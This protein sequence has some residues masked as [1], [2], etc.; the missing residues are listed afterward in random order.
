MA[1]FDN[2]YRADEFVVEI[3]GEESPTVSKVTGLSRGETGT[4]E[5][6][7][8]G[9]NAV[10]LVSDGVVKWPTLTIERYIDGSRDD[11]LFKGFFEE[12]FKLNEG[13]I[14]SNCRR[15]I[16]IVK[17]HFGEEVMRFLVYGAFPTKASFTD[18]EAGSKNLFKETIEF[19]H[20]GIR[21]V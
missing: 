9:T 2:S 5:V 15:D 18:L 21:C 16:A 7:E 13:G 14:G 10:H 12:M 17:K 20:D 19:A 3:Q 11:Q 1:N 4:I 6:I 8:G